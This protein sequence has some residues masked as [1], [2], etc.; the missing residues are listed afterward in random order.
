MSEEAIVD[1][2]STVKKIIDKTCEDYDGVWQKRH[3]VLSTK[4]ILMMIFRMAM[5]QRRQGLSINLTEFWDTCSE[6]G[7]ALPQEKSVA[8][9]SFC[10]AR[11]KV[12]ETIFKDLNKSLLKNWSEQRKLHRWLGHRVFAVDGS[13]VNIP[14]ELTSSGFKVFDETR[15]HY[16]QGLLSCLYDILGKTVYDFDFV[17]HINERQC[18]LDHLKVLRLGDV[19]IFDRGYFSYLL[20][21]EFY[22]AGVYVLFRLQEGSCNKEIEDFM[23]GSKKDDIITYIPSSTVI[24]DL[25]KQGYLLKPK[26]IP[27]RLFKRDIK[28]E[29]YTYGTTLSK[30]KYPTPYLMDLYH[31]RWKI[32]ELYKITKKISEIEEFHS[33]TERGVKQEIYAHLL[34][35][36]L[37]RFF[38]FDAKD[39]LPP[40]HPEDAEKCVQADFYKFF[41]PA[42]MFNI[43]FKNC[44]TIVGR[45]LENLILGAYEKIKSWAPKVIQMVLRIRQKIRPGRS[46][47]RRSFKPL[48][49]WES[50]GRRAKMGY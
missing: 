16:P 5:S 6:K 45:Y 32:E 10:E 41:N 49:K 9:S 48:G 2:W 25:K 4:I 17:S 50:T 1:Y 43:N 19:V 24:S 8:A 7:V 34:L 11:Q 33:K 28:G 3:R 26:P 37:S 35:V 15:R 42:T 20:L 36:N 31:E 12:S 18:A 13:R 46:F 38:E 47:P 23:K 21:H 22:N 39:K 30:S 40:M 14:R 44:L 27:F 29:T